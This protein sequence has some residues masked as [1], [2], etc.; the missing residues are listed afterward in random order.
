[1]S[2]ATARMRSAYTVSTGIRWR[3]SCVP[4]PSMYQLRKHLSADPR[5]LR[6]STRCAEVCHPYSQVVPRLNRATYHHSPRCNAGHGEI[7]VQQVS[8]GAE[9]FPGHHVDAQPPAN[10]H[11]Q[12]ARKGCAPGMGLDLDVVPGKGYAV[13]TQAGQARNHGRPRSVL[14]HEAQAVLLRAKACEVGEPLGQVARKLGPRP[15]RW[16]RG[17]HREAQLGAID[18]MSRN[19]EGGL[20]PVIARDLQW[21]AQRGRADRRLQGSRHLDIGGARKLS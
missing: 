10:R 8:S 13:E 5:L 14:E 17:G 2:A 18:H 16:K 12:L 7:S 6:V 9:G 11:V 4:S 21:H 1:M 19:A 15:R 3:A 20:K